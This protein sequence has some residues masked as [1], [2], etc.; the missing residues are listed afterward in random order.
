LRLS[1]HSASQE[2]PHLVWNPQVHYCVHKA[3]PL[4]HIVSQ[5]NPVDTL[6]PYFPKIHPNIV[7]CAFLIS[8][9][10]TA[11]PAHLI[12]LDL[13][14]QIMFGEVYKLQS[15]SFCSLLQPPTIASCLGPSLLL[16]TLFSYTLNPSSSLVMRDQVSHPH[17]TAGKISILYILIFEFFRKE[18]G[19]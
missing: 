10:C 1:S 16:S 18:L 6:P 8:P 17:K 15:F 4:V 11:C 9:M 12:L 5:M 13:I 7:L 14:T 2:I 3:M 19:R